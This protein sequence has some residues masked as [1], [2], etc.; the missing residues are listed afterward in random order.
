[1]NTLNKKWKI[2]DKFKVRNNDLYPGIY[3]VDSVDSTHSYVTTDSNGHCFCFYDYEI[4]KI[5]ESTDSQQE[6]QFFKLI[7]VNK[8]MP[9]YSVKIDGTKQAI[10]DFFFGTRLA[11][12][13][14]IKNDKLFMIETSK[15]LK[16]LYE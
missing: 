5:E 7:I 3:K 8:N 14:V 16:K 9:E 6:Y 2:G 15:D 1:M 13:Y 4:E 12:F 10:D 11:D